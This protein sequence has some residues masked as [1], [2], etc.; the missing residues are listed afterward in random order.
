MPRN[1]E[2]TGLAASALGIGVN[3]LLAAVKILAGAIG[4]S[5][6][7][8]ADGIESVADVVSSLVVWGG[9]WVASRP[10]D[11]NHPYGHGRAETVAA[12]IVSGL[13]L[14]SAALIATQSIHEIWNSNHSTSPAPFTLAVLLGVIV[15]KELLFRKVVAAGESIDSIAL[16]G[17]A[18]HHRSDA[19]TSGAA[20]IGISV[21]LV[22]GPAYQWAD[23]F[24]ALAACSVIA[25][26]GLRFARRAI[27]ELMDTVVSE[28]KLDAVRWRAQNVDDVKCVEECRIRKSGV[29]Y[30]VDIHVQVN[31]SLSVREGHE[32]A[33][34]V[35]SALMLE[36]RSIQDV[37]VHIE[38]APAPVQEG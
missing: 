7:L 30:L 13:L 36:D 23:G 26:N 37:L 1:A 9:F 17:D 5:Y 3:T 33:H 21:A 28:D 15:V 35:K 12:L 4:H 2:Q 16:Q 6:A 24:A 8:I 29:R 25:L 10:P 14:G 19:F 32:I 18:W 38:P 31:G 27:I 11:E 22:G 20:F 34:A